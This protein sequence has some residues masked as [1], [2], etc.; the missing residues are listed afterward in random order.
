M[1]ETLRRPTFCEREG[2]NSNEIHSRLGLGSRHQFLGQ[3][4]RLLLWQ[5]PPVGLAI[6]SVLRFAVYSSSSPWTCCELS[7]QLLLLVEQVAR[8]PNSI[9]EESFL[10]LQAM[11]L[12]FARRRQ[13]RLLHLQQLCREAS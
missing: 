5:P 7:L 4:R 3:L 1:N 12:P 8:L 10:G 13:V 9:W 11:L 6:C 2:P